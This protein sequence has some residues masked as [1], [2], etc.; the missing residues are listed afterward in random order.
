MEPHPE[1]E[2]SSANDPPVSDMS[3]YDAPDGH[4]TTPK[5]KVYKSKAKQGA[6]LAR[7]LS[8]EI[9][10]VEVEKVTPPRRLK[11]RVILSD[12]ES[13]TSSL[14]PRSTDRK[15]KR[16][17]SSIERPDVEERDSYSVTEMA[18]SPLRSRRL[19][20]QTYRDPAPRSSSSVSLDNIADLG[21]S[22]DP[23]AFICTSRTVCCADIFPLHSTPTS[24][25]TV[26]GSEVSLFQRFAHRFLARSSSFSTAACYTE[27]P[28]HSPP[29]RS[30]LQSSATICSIYRPT[31]TTHH[32]TSGTSTVLPDDG[33]YT[34][35]N[36]SISA[37][38]SGATRGGRSFHISRLSLL[39]VALATIH[40][41]AP[42]PCDFPRILIRAFIKTVVYCYNTLAS[43]PLSVFVHSVSEQWN[44]P[45]LV[46]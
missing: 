25:N 41:N 23:R 39:S 37:V 45:A 33:K 31:R 5:K 19:A 24:K 4:V 18:S 12:T 20:N 35:A 29:P 2:A 8:G 10:K 11:P 21:S 36:P 1:C 40:S 26:K 38:E 46:S 44:P 28:R 30:T 14:H 32:F 42:S 16:A 3:A 7:K 13:K 27:R 17:T 22:K 34:R 6:Q 43:T 15:R 9:P